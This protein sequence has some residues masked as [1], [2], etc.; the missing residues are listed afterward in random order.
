MGNNYIISEAFEQLASMH[1][2]KTKK[3]IKESNLKVKKTSLVESDDEDDFE[4]DGSYY[5]DW[6][7]ED[8][9]HPAYSSFETACNNLGVWAEPSIQGRRGADWI[10]SIDDDRTLAVIDYE[11]ECAEM[12]DIGYRL[13][14]KNITEEEA[15]KEIESWL[16]DQMYQYVPDDEFDDGDELGYQSEII[17]YLETNNQSNELPG[18]L[19]YDLTQHI[20]NSLY[21]KARKRSCKLLDDCESYRDVMIKIENML[22]TKK[23]IENI[24]AEL[25]TSDV[26]YAYPNDVEPTLNYMKTRAPFKVVEESK[27]SMSEWFNEALMSSEDEHDSKILADIYDKISSP[28]RKWWTPIKLS[29]EQQKVLDKYNLYIVPERREIRKYGSGYSLMS[30]NDRHLSNSHNDGLV[31]WDDDKERGV[32]NRNANLADRARKLGTKIDWGSERSDADGWDLDGDFQ[33]SLDKIGRWPG[34]ETSPDRVLNRAQAVRM[35]RPIQ[36]MKQALKDRNSAEKNI[37]ELKRIKKEYT[38]KKKDAQDR[39]DYY[40]RKDK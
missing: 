7:E 8:M 25:I 19:L 24:L 20:V 23:G 11:D 34:A 33:D 10:R 32:A 14:S 35:H 31:T 38:N 30:R 29:K 12:D 15:V 4:D 13:V 2:K 3:S 37:D 22:L 6:Y 40:L 16:K 39:I 27:K 21:T 18:Y 5:P 1:K 28:T 26:N 17:E 36:N 9:D